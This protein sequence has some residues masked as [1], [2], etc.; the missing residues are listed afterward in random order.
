MRAVLLSRADGE[1]RRAWNA[2][3]TYGGPFCRPLRVLEMMDA[4][5]PPA[6]AE[7]Y[8]L[9]ARYAGVL[10]AI[11]ARPVTTVRTA[12]TVPGAAVGGARS[13]APGFSRGGRGASQTSPRSGR[14]KT[15]NDRHSEV[16]R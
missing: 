5:D 6:E 12:Q 9:P 15:L 2:P 1:G 16:L 8:L 10:A 14:Q 3:R 4:F 13:I 11:R 7:G